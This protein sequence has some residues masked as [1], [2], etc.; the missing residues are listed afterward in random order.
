MVDVEPNSAHSL[1]GK[2]SLANVLSERIVVGGG[3]D[4]MVAER[5]RLESKVPDWITWR[6]I[7]GGPAS[8]ADTWDLRRF[9]RIKRT[10]TSMRQSPATQDATITPIAMSEIPLEAVDLEPKL[11]AV[12]TVPVTS[13]RSAEVRTD[14][15]IASA[16][17]LL[18][19]E[20]TTIIL[21]G[22]TFSIRSREVSIPWSRRP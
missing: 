18:T 15:F 17:P 7:G 13:M 3:A 21:P 6:D 14:C 22:I 2:I 1:G 16:T 9:W 4:D 10:M 11:E 20:N 12:S 19:E 5:G 8:W